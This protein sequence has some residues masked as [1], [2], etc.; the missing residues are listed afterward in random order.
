MKH[1][2]FIS[3]LL[4]L[5]S[6]NAFGR[7]RCSFKRYPWT[8]ADPRSQLDTA[9]VIEIARK[10]HAYWTSHSLYL[11]KIKF[12]HDKAEWVV[13]SAKTKHTNKGEC[14]H[15][16]G[17]T[18]ITTVVLIINDKTKR[19]KSKRKEKKTIPNYE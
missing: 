10:K 5:L 12:D 8:L 19:V 4:V 17:C 6:L 1:I 3:A 7:E 9:E 14:K 2:R 11:P 16:N 13:Q 18:T 15:T